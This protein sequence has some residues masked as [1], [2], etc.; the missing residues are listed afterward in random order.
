MDET[1]KKLTDTLKELVE[2]EE[3]KET[4]NS[5]WE[6]LKKLIPTA[7]KLETETVKKDKYKITYVVIGAISTV[8]TVFTLFRF[9][10]SY[11]NPEAIFIVDYISYQF[12]FII[13]IALAIIGIVNILKTEDKEEV[14]DKV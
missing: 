1:V 4:S 10:T 8:W 11:F 12:L 7:P 5:K 3:P 14:E 6:W 13:V 2:E 9:L